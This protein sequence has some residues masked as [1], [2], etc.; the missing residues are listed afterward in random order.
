MNTTLIMSGGIRLAVFD[1]LAKTVIALSSMVGIATPKRALQFSVLGHKL[2]QTTHT[3]EAQIKQWF[4]D[5]KNDDESSPPPTENSG[6]SVPVSGTTEED[7]IGKL[8]HEVNLLDCR[9]ALMKK[10]I[11]DVKFGKKD[12]PISNLESELK[13]LEE[14]QSKKLD[15]A[16]NLFK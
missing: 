7:A 5:S 1:P 11:S 12:E 13:K 10:R 9:I 4:E 15:E 16:S 8:A 3:V 14:E 2:D 6:S